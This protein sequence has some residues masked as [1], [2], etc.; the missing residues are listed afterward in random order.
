MQVRA[1]IIILLATAAL[2]GC[3]R[4]GPLE[5]PPAK[6]VA[7]ASQTA[8]DQAPAPPPAPPQRHHFLLDFLL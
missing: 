5:D 6:P 1:L 2:A 3:G 7:P 4:Y 8:P